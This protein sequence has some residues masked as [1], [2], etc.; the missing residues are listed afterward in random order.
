MLNFLPIIIFFLVL[1]FYNLSIA[2][3]VLSGYYLIFFILLKLKKDIFNK[4]YLFYSI[5]LFLLAISAILFKNEYIIKW[6]PSIVNWLLSII[7]L[8]FYI[9]KK[10][11]IHSYLEKTKIK[12]N[13]YT[14][15]Y[16][17]ISFCLFFFILGSLNLYIA[18]N[19][20]TKTWLIFKF[21][22]LP[23]LM[24]IFCIIQLIILRK[25]IKFNNK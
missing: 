11:F 15:N 7:F 10:P 5:L 12:L 1:N 13:I 17:N 18:Y 4:K 23:L 24:I 8:Y 19:V 6:K 16:I 14:V 3:L 20:N 9:L 21:I 2:T 25:H 22:I